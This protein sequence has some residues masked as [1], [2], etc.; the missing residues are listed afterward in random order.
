M[1]RDITLLYTSKA[2]GERG[3]WGLAAEIDAVALTRLLPATAAE[4]PAWSPPAAVAA[5][6]LAV[7]VSSFG[8]LLAICDPDLP[9]DWLLVRG[10]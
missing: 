8:G 1:V 9:E 4:T 5:A 2:K 3:G 6:V 7:L 10:L